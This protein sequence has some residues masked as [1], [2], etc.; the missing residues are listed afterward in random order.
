MKACPP[1]HLL[2]GARGPRWCAVGALWFALTFGISA[3]AKTASL[4]DLSAYPPSISLGS[5]NAFQRVVVQAAYSD[6]ST[7]DVSGQARYKLAD[8]KIARLDHEILKPLKD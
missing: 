3:S 4:T 8:P 5:A 7:R 1:N 6:G 2:L